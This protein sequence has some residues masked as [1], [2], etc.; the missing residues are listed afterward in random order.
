[1]IDNL[2]E[3]EKN[4]LER[5]VRGASLGEC[6]D[7]REFAITWHGERAILADCDDK[8]L[9]PGKLGFELQHRAAIQ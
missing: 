2:S 8:Q 4:V 5:L 9:D 7:R 3:R 1:M 6:F